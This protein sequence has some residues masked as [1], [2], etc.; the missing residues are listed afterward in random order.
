MSQLT[1]TPTIAPITGTDAQAG[2]AHAGGTQ[3][4]VD[5]GT[6]TKSDRI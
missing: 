4:I 6:T 5:A 2:G 3:D 1:T